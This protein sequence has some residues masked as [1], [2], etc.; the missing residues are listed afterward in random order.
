MT[1]EEMSCGIQKRTLEEMRATYTGGDE[2]R[3]TRCWGCSRSI[4]EP[5]CDAEV[6]CERAE[7]AVWEWGMHTNV[8]SRKAGAGVECISEAN[9]A[10]E[11]DITA[12]KREESHFKLT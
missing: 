1:L 10:S 6:L 3:N 9:K 5:Q 8:C 4:L 11:A 7:D 12:S 2:L